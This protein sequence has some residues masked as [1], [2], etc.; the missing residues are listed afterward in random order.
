MKI[1]NSTSRKKEQIKKN[2]CIFITEAEAL[3]YFTTALI[4]RNH[5]IILDKS[6]L[7][8][9]PNCRK[10]NNKKVHIPIIK[11]GICAFLFL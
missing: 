8:F 11:T 2:L 9:L 10:Y 5:Y 3:H 4:P 7:Y 6:F 1:L